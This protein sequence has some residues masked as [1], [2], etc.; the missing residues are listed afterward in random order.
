MTG[1]SLC[2]GPS[3]TENIITQ[4]LKTSV[5]SRKTDVASDRAGL[6]ACSPLA[7]RGASMALDKKAEIS[8]A[9]HSRRAE[10]LEVV[11][12]LGCVY[13]G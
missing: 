1:H 11:A 13:V 2:T 8:V 6:S 4:S 5:P 3:K 10:R 12:Q 9:R 7:C